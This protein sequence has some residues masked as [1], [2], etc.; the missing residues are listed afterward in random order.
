MVDQQQASQSDEYVTMEKEERRISDLWKKE[1]WM[2]IWLG[3]ILL[4]TGLLIYLLNPPAKME[5]KFDKYNQIMKEEASKAPFKTI[6]WHKASA[7]KKKI[8]ARDESHGKTIQE[9]LKAPDKWATNPVDSLYRS[10]E[11][12]DSMNAKGKEGF[13]KA[14]AAEQTAFAAAQTAEQKAAQAGFKD[15][16]LNK[17]AE[18]E[19]AKW[20]KS[21][22]ALSKAKAKTANKPYNR[23][24]YLVGLAIML[25]VFF[26]IGKIVMGE[27]FGKFLV[28]FFFVF[29]F[30]VLAYIAEVQHT[31]EQY[32]FG[33]PLWA[34]IF[35]MLVSNTVGTPGWVKPGVQTEYYIKTGLV[36]LGAEILMNKMLAIGTPGIF[37]AWIDTPFILIVT[38]WF[39]QR[40]VKIPSRTLNIT[41]CAD[42]SVC[43]VSAAIATAAAC[44]AKKEELTLAVGLSMV[45]TALCMVIQPAIAKLVGM[46]QILAGAWMGG[47][48]DSTGAVAAAGAFY[49]EQ[50]LYVAATLKM[51]QNVSIGFIAFGV[52]YYWCAKVE[53]APGQTVSLWEIWDRFPKFVLGFILAS[54][55][56]SFV[57]GSVTKDYSTAMIDQGVLRGF[58]R[59]IREWCFALAF[60]SIGLETNFRDFRP[61]MKGGKPFIL[62][63]AG[64]T[65]DLIT[66]LIMAYVFFYLLFP[67][68][69]AKI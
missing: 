57:D 53:C 66:T 18:T 30:A 67:E 47:T 19:I 51:I 35:G 59:L 39:G 62:Y 41:I 38:Y 29:V 14:K 69:L 68:M 36:L 2:V 13:E 26:G 34:I 60:A 6:A 20:L 65:L 61:Y 56:F 32:G 16:A 11:T 27:S 52:A 42:M 48:I 37:V 17:A 25:G 44:R 10:K 5:E 15:G 40:I 21:N 4:A 12:A 22:E 63:G 54:I 23:V 1:D 9:F 50:A 58:T 55:I 7:D 46:P 33:F 43:G 28:G 64:Q 8:R 31:M 24:P 49:G 45:F 3:F